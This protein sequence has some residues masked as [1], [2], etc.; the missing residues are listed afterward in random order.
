M[1]QAQERLHYMDNLRALIMTAG[2][3]FHAALAYSPYMHPIWLTADPAKAPAMDWLV[4]FLHTFRMPLF[5][6]IAGFF[7]AVLIERR[8]LQGMLKNR[9]LR[10]IIPLALFWPIIY[11]CV[12]LPAGWAIM[13]VDNLSPLL[14]FIKTAANKADVPPSHPST[15]H[16]WFLYYLVFYY[17]IAWALQKLPL[18]RLKRTVLAVHP[19]IALLMFP[20]ALAPWLWTTLMPF[21]A[22]NQFMPQFWAF[23]FFG[24][25]F[26]YGYVLFSSSRQLDFF[27]RYWSQLILASLVL[28]LVFLKFLPESAMPREQVLTAKLALTLCTAYMAVFMSVAC[29][30]GARKLL[31]QRNAF[32]GYMADA[33]Y[34]IYIAHFPIVLGIQYW[35]MD[36]PGGAWYKFAVS[37]LGALVIC[38]VSYALLVRGTPIGWLLNGQRKQ[39]VQSP[40]TESQLVS[41]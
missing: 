15:L 5:F 1:Y 23:G 12:R 34:W 25:F 31:N 35:L 30:V 17:S 6:I 11:I 37:S 13:N 20:L 38:V 40:S 9:F 21:P 26:A 36:Q 19:L 33:S 8:G 2:V 18:N 28:S 22:P 27:D 29:L 10:V 41:K 14:G 3:F 7:T 16:L 39:Q 32:M 24:L 4:N